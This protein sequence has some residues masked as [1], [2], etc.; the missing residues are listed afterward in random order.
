[1]EM[2]IG[3][4]LADLRRKKGLTQGQLAEKLG[5][6]P[7]AVSKWET[8]H[9]CPDITLLCPLARALDTNV[10]TLLQFEENLSDEEMTK[11]IQEVLETARHDGYEAGES[12]LLQL[13]HKYP[14][15]IALKYNA[16]IVWNSFQ[17]FFPPVSNEL[18]QKWTVYRKELLTEVRSS[19]ASVYWQTATLRLA[20][21]ATLRLAEMA[22][23]A[24]DIQ[25]GEALLKELPEQQ[26]DPSA[27]WALLHLKK[28]EPQEALKTVQKRLYLIVRQVQSCLTMMLNPHITADDTLALKICEVLK[29]MDDLFGLG[30][31]YDG[32]FMEIYMRMHRYQDAADSLSRYADVVTG[33]ANLPKQ[34]LFTPGLSLKEH[35]PA[36]INELREM[37]LKNLESEEYKPL[38]EYPQYKAAI[39]KIKASL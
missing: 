25:Q 13:L 32:F 16:A 17:M 34:F 4:K 18:R 2:D 39:E 19:G 23:S 11:K 28:E 1:M 27:A 7:A 9:S 37:L 21:M 29:V 5:I 8:G 36:M 33:E 24:G 35:Q 3:K 31:M 12:K 10:D 14:N 15:S 22:I 20:E 38:L 30:G 6:S 26:E